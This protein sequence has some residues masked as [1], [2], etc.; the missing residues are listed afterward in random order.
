MSDRVAVIGAG[1]WGTAVAALASASRP[2]TLWARSPELASAM[3][4]SRENATYLPGVNLPSGLTVT[5][6]LEEAV[7]GAGVIF[8]A[9]P[10]HGFRAVLKD[11]RP[12]ALRRAMPSSA[13]P[14]A[15]S[16]VPTCGCPR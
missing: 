7:S 12:F 13:L 8:M 3:E 6:S 15:L 11:L 10:S 14:R 4:K 16:P 9:V 5:S 1:S 2:A